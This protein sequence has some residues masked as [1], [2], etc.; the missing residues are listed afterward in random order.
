MIIMYSATFLE[1]RIL[2]LG[3]SI[4]QSKCT[5]DTFPHDFYHVKVQDSVLDTSFQ[6]RVGENW[7]MKNIPYEIF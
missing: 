7:H 6:E 3:F 1:Y 5:S 4:E 2:V